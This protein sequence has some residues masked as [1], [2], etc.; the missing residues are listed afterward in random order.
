MR[1]LLVFC[2]LFALR[3]WVRGGSTGLEISW[4]GI[5]YGD[6]FH[7][8][9]AIRWISGRSDRKRVQL[10]YQTR[11]RGLAGFDRPLPLDQNPTAE[12][13]KRLMES[14]ENALREKHPDLIIG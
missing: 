7:S 4:A 6:V 12:E 10:F 2:G 14:L 5:R 3:R 13:Y 9:D 8:W 11:S 1:W